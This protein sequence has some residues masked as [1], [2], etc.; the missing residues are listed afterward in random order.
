MK[1]M[2]SPINSCLL[3]DYTCSEKMQPVLIKT[4]KVNLIQYV[5]DRSL[6]SNTEESCTRCYELFNLSMLR[7]C[8][9]CSR[10]FCKECLTGRSIWLHAA[11]NCDY[12]RGISHNHSIYHFCSP[13]CIDG[14]LTL[15]S[16]KR[17]WCVY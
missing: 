1:N 5:D 16:K 11:L 13:I 14:F 15:R 2:D 7:K 4:V 9:G 12:C 8:V 3:N 17:I 6:T 10:Y